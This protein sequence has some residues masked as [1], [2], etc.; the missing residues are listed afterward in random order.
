[1]EEEA[2]QAEQKRLAVA[3]KEQQAAS[4][5]AAKAYEKGRKDA[6]KEALR[7]RNN[8]MEAKAR[9]EKRPIYTDANGVIQSQYT[10]DKWEIRII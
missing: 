8:E 3:V 5:D 7:A 4:E 2:F 1:M 10:D 6:D 9:R